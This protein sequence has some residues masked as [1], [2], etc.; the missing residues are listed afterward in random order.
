MSAENLED[1]LANARK[2]LEAPSLPHEFYS[3]ANDLNSKLLLSDPS[4]RAET[5]QSVLSFKSPQLTPLFSLT[6]A[7]TPAIRLRT[8]AS[9]ASPA[10]STPHSRT[11]PLPGLP[12]PDVGNP[13]QLPHEHADSTHPTHH[14]PLFPNILPSFPFLDAVPELNEPGITSPP[15]APTLSLPVAVP[16]PHLPDAFP[17]AL[18]HPRAVATYA[19]Y[20][21]AQRDYDRALAQWQQAR[22]HEHVL[23]ALDGSHDTALEAGLSL[24]NDRPAPLSTSDPPP[25]YFHPSSAAPAPSPFRSA[26]LPAP[27]DPLFPSHAAA[28]S[29]PLAADALVSQCV[30]MAT[31]MAKLWPRLR[32]IAR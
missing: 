28:M 30:V 11:S 1:I 15:V 32:E 3:I 17:F 27:R 23:G 16:P 26:A 5:P 18:T 9:T 20:A 25:T 4:S 24:L 8:A 19:E 22:A 29:S 6:P 14:A 7:D 12:S 31:L 2:L 10:I 13:F 21:A